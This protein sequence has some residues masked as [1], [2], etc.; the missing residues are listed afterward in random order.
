M[1]LT[2]SILEEKLSYFNDPRVGIFS[3][4]YIDHTVLK[5]H[6]VHPWQPHAYN[7]IM[8]QSYDK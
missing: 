5:D 6:F 8:L 3:E 4:R 1:I 2:A 7:S